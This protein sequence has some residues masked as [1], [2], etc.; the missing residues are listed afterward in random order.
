M[1]R[2]MKKYE[3]VQE[4]SESTKKYKKYG[5]AQEVRRST[6]VCIFPLG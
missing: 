6:E 2:R 5:E 4:G 3:N 1:S